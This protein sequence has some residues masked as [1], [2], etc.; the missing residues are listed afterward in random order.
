MHPES[1]SLYYRVINCVQS[2]SM[3]GEN[4]TWNR[5]VASAMLKHPPPIVT[6]GEINDEPHRL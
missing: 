1:F 6:L 3:N 2:I 5:K 4:G